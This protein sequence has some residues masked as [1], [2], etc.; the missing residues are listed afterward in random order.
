MTELPDNNEQEARRWLGNVEDDLRAMHAL[1][2]DHESPARIVCFL[3]HLAVEKALK[4]ALIDVGVPFRKTHDIVALY[5][6]CRAAK[7]LL[8]L[9]ASAL[10]ALQPWA[11]DGRYADDLV[12]ASHDVARRLMALADQVVTEVRSELEVVGGDQ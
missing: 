12:D 6:M 7:R 9:D 11:I 8:A 5:E 4:A 3:A 2:R 1:E 10:A